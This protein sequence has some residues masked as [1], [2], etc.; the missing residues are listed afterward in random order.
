MIID[1]VDTAIRS[2]AR[3]KKVADNIG[4]SART[5]IRWRKQEAGGRDR[6]TGPL[7]APG[8]KLNEKERQQ[9]I[10]IANSASFRNLSPKQIVP[11]LADQGIYL[12]SE[13]SFYRILKEQ[14]MMT[15]RQASKPSTP[16]R[17]KE[18]LATGPCQVWS[19]DITYLKTPVKGL[20]FY[21]YM[22]VDVWSRKI[23]AAQVFGEE[24]S[25][26]SSMLLAHACMVHGIAPN[27]LVL[28]SDNGGPMKGATMLATMHKLGVM[29]SFSRPS[30]SNDNP[31][32]ESLFRTMKYRPEYPDKPFATIEQAQS[33]VDGFLFWY[34]TQHQH[35]AIR[36]VTPDDRHYGKEKQLL[37][38]RRKVYNDARS[39]HPERW[40]KQIRNWNPVRTVQ[41]NPEK[42]DNTKQMNQLKMAA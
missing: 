38:N 2:G 10:D 40:S 8:N 37:N 11:K 23:V 42:K 41:L 13:S 28:H 14:Q 16:R 32:S 18:H 5:L 19:W 36:F 26:Y 33:W 31:Y 4:V 22:I 12:A 34:N 1:L 17:P 15:H 30:V 39:R 24:S 27:K 29:P 20:F 9:V 3:L 21:L 6:R 25:D 7:T 35:S